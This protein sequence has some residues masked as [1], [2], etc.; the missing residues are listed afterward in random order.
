[1]L[2]V[3]IN[4]P[5]GIRKRVENVLT[6]FEKDIMNSDD[7]DIYGVAPVSGLL[8]PL[9]HQDFEYLVPLFKS[10]LVPLVIGMNFSFTVEH[11]LKA[12]LKKTC[13]TV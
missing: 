9:S 3:L 1:M 12:L 5:Q 6:D 4:F 10:N 8:N 11:M 7:E 2:P 13:E